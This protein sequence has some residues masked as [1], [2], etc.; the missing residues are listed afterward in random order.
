MWDIFFYLRKIIILL[1]AH[2][3]IYL[4]S[5]KDRGM[6]GGVARDI[7]IPDRMCAERQTR[8]NQDKYEFFYNYRCVFCM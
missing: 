6:G 8:I 5:Y 3:G 1:G 7:V 2:Y 4:T